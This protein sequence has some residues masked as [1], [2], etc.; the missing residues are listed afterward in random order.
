MTEIWLVALIRAWQITVLATSLLATA[1]ALPRV[2]GTAYF[3][4]LQLVL[5]LDG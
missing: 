5:A 1:L 2:G 3:Q 4:A